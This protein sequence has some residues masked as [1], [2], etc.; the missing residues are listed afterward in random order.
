MIRTPKDGEGENLRVVLFDALKQP[1]YFQRQVQWLQSKFPDASYA[2]VEGVC[3]STTRAIIEDNEC[4]LTPGRY[5]GVAPLEDDPEFDYE[6]RMTSI[7]DELS[8]LNEQ[9]FSLAQMIDN[10]LAEILG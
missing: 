4:S 7:R 2:D 6:E 1:G 3:K 5:V 9:A 8:S 10:D